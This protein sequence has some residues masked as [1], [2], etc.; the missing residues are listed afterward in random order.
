[1]A[2]AHES[3]TSAESLC[4]HVAG[5]TRAQFQDLTRR[6]LVLRGASRDH[7]ACDIATGA[8]GEGLRAKAGR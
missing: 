6:R 8:A 4:A 7:H 2:D 5:L 3:Q 1:M